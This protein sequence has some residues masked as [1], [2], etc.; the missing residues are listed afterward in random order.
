MWKLQTPNFLKYSINSKILKD[1][2]AKFHP[3]LVVLHIIIVSILKS[4]VQALKEVSKIREWHL[5]WSEGRVDV[6][7]KSW[8]DGVNSE[9]KLPH[10]QSDLRWGYQ[11]R[12]IKQ[13]KEHYSCDFALLNCLCSVSPLL[14]F[15]WHYHFGSSFWNSLQRDERPFH[16]LHEILK[17]A[18]KKVDWTP[19]I[20][21]TTRSYTVLRDSMDQVLLRDRIQRYW[22]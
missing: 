11:W 4:N 16:Q 2:A 22:H 3:Y 13:F 14:R 7:R 18:E 9:V 17:Q 8:K 20:E 1:Q 15:S 5:S 19:G 10:H 12:R 21:R 6:E